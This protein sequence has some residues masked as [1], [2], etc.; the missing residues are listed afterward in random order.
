M[1]EKDLRNQVI[2][3]GKELLQDGL[4]ARTWGN[5]SARVDSNRFLIT[6]SGLDYL[7][8]QEEDLVLYRMKEGTWEGKRKPSSEKAIHVAA[9]EV[10]PDAGFVIHTHQKYASAI[11]L[12]GFERLRLSKDE[13]KML[14]RI[15]VAEYGLPGS[16]KLKD[17]VKDLFKA[18]VHTV[19]MKHHGA[20]IVGRTK[21]EA[22][23]RALLLEEVCKRL[24]APEVEPIQESEKAELKT[25]QDDL[26]YEIKKSYPGVM[27]VDTPA[28]VQRSG[29]VTPIVAQ[30]DDMAQMIGKKIDVVVEDPEAVILQF[31]TGRNT[32]L[33]KDLGAFVAG[34]D[35]DDTEALKLLA[36]KACICSI[37][38][39]G[40]KEKKS[41]SALDCAR[42]RYVY[43]RK[44]SKQKNG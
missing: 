13:G 26:L 32:V 5:V 41:L 25:R 36:D 2:A 30:L 15:G 40:A 37:H 28:V 10:F 24:C 39:R 29:D 11:G 31:K 34:M 43:K 27:V 4:V 18:G 17:A 6:P 44:Y 38:T 19:L 33:V 9:Y 3:T 8:T 1:T 21:E 20:V 14:G 35:S 42:M 7:Q 16:M 23:E 12:E 22:Y